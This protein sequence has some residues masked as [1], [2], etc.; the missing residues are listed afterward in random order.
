MMAPNKGGDRVMTGHFMSPN[1]SSSKRTGLHS[2]E[3]LA[4]RGPMEI[5]E[6]PRLLLR[7]GIILCKLIV[8]SHC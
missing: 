6:Q 7:Q 1:K 5:H 3:L 2:I 8:E 4:K